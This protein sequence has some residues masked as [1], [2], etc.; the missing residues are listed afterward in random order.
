MDAHRLELAALAY[1]AAAAMYAA[2]YGTDLECQ[3]RQDYCTAAG[4][5]F[6]AAAAFARQEA[7]AR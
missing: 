1:A 3:A 4:E 5:L 2:L 7:E 6:L